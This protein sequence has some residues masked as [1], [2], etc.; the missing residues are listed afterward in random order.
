MMTSRTTTPD[1]IMIPRQKIE[2]DLGYSIGF[3]LGGI[4]IWAGFLV[5]FFIGY[6][7]PSPAVNTAPFA[8][9]TTLF[10]GAGSVFV[11]IGAIFAAINWSMLRK[12]RK[13]VIELP[14][15]S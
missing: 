12:I 4:M 3:L 2:R 1:A 15:K 5:L 8:V 13:S 11:L 9:L 6:L 14:G 7:F 10:L